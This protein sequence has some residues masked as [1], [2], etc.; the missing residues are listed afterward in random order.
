VGNFRPGLGGYSGAFP[1]PNGRDVVVFAK[2]NGYIVDPRTRALQ[3]EFGG[4]IAQV[5]EV[6]DPPGLVC[7]RQGLAIFR[8]GPEG[9]VWHT[10]RLSWDGFQNVA[11]TPTAITGLAFGLGDAWEP[12]EVDL[13]SGSSLGGAVLGGVDSDW[14]VLARPERPG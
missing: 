13:A 10:R 5:W 6:T 14:E 11:L 4:A 7:D 3:K 8:I 9:V 2:G 1:H 12:F